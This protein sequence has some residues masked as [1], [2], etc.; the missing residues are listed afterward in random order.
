MCSRK[1]ERI[2]QCR[3]ESTTVQVGAHRLSVGLI[4]AAV[5][6]G[7]AGAPSPG[8]ASATVTHHHT[9]R[10]WVGAWEAPP[11]SGGPAD[12]DQSYRQFIHLSIGGPRLRLHF[13]NSYGTKPVALRDVTVAAAVGP[14]APGIR[15]TTM[16]RVRFAGGTTLTIPAG[17]E[18]AS[19]PVAFDVPASGWIAVS[20]YAPGRDAATTWH[21]QAWGVNLVTAP[22]AG[23][24]SADPASTAF[25]VPL[26]SWTYLS[27]VDVMAPRRVSTVVAFGDS[28]TDCC[29]SIPDASDRWPDLLNHR[30]SELPGSR[31]YS[32]IDAGISGNDV[33][34]DR[35]GNARQGQAGDVRVA[36]DALEVPGVSTIILFE[37]V[38]D[39]GTGV[40]AK[41][42][43]A[44]Y[45]KILRAAHERDVRVLIST[46]T[47]TYG[48]A[49]SGLDYTTNAPARDQVNQWIERHRHR[50]GGVL[51]FGTVVADPLAPNTWNPAYTIGDQLHPNPVGLEVMADSIPL[52]LFRP[53][54]SVS[55]R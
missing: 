15:A 50:F 22:G 35:N 48:A 8:H 13:S 19:R 12:D 23:N 26:P 10:H 16:R 27:E 31:R 7:I 28:I 20:F 44:A 54:R 29:M 51:H 53:R 39:V 17:Q 3:V 14:P 33:S 5:A 45:L 46:L 21:A 25:D 9:P 55:R 37:G 34:D 38:N 11:E 40:S 49:A 36:R 52:R 4:T 41:R 18:R 6:I 30:L 1:Q 42:I 47:P 2:T 32:V 24:H 43:E